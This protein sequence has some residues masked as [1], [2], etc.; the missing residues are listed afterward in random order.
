MEGKELKEGSPKRRHSGCSDRKKSS[1]WLQRFGRDEGCC[2][3]VP[4]ER[5]LRSPRLPRLGLPQL[6][7]TAVTTSSHVLQ[8]FP[9]L[10]SNQL[11][12]L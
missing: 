1:R 3:S 8:Y 5:G 2:A 12:S 4:C 7:A 9:I 10:A 11:N 6:L